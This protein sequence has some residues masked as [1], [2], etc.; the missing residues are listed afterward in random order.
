LLHIDIGNTVNII[1]ST[2]NSVS[3]QIKS[4]D[5]LIFEGGSLERDEVHWMKKFNK[6]S[7]CSLKEKGIHYLTINHYFPA[8]SIISENKKFVAK[9]S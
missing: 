6:T 2:Y 9:L 4:C 3:D 7:I 5:S 8:L 1:E